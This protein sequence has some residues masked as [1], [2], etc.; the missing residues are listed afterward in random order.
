MVLMHYPDGADRVPVDDFLGWAR[1][2][3]RYIFG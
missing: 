2:G 1:Q 3:M